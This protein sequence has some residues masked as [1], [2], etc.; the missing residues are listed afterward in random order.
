M[1]NRKNRVRL[2]ALRIECQQAFESA[3][4]SYLKILGNKVDNPNTSQK[5]Y[6]KIIN[7]VINKCRARKIPPRMGLF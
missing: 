2:D 3:K 4:L 5:P 6:W 1:L 7:K